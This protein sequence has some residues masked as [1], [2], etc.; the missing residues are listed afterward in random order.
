MD[1]VKRDASYR[2][3]ST[4]FFCMTYAKPCEFKFALEKATHWAYIYH[5]RDENE[6]HFHI[7]LHFDNARTGFAL[8][9]DFHSTANTFIESKVSPVDSYEYLYHANHPDKYQYDKSLIV[10]HNPV[11]WEHFLPSVRD[12]TQ[13]DF[14]EDL[15]NSSDLDLVYMAKKYGR[16][17]IKNYRTYI[18][19]RNDVL[20]LTKKINL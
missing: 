4:W 10:S 17:F 9:N 19:F 11:Y 8:L 14:I 18:E 13:T 12:R 3:R 20:P 5:D 7:L 6:P 1:N 15:L 2:R 16:D